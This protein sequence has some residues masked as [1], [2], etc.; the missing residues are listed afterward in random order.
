[1][2]PQVKYIHFLLDAHPILCVYMHTH[3]QWIIV[4]GEDEGFSP[5]SSVLHTGF[6][7]LC[8]PYNANLYGGKLSWLHALLVIHRKSFVIA[9]LEQFAEKSSTYV[10][11]YVCIHVLSHWQLEYCWKNYAF[12]ASMSIKIIEHSSLA[13]D[14]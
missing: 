3:L 14:L 7:I 8:I 1:M 2:L 9:W 11:S 13:S 6:I 10:C 4:K 5:P 12:K